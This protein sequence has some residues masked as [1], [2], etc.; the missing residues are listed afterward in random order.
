MGDVVDDVGDFWYFVGD[1]C[2]DCFEDG[3]G[4][5]GEAGGH[6]FAAFCG[7]DG[8]DVAVCSGVAFDACGF[9]VC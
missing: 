5:L 9:G 8:N 4:D 3:V 7:S 2:G 6:G 1:S